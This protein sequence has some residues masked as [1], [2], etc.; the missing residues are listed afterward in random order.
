[1]MMMMIKKMRKVIV[2]MMMKKKAILTIS[3]TRIQNLKMKRMEKQTTLLH[4]SIRSK[5]ISNKIW[6]RL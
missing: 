6:K 2:M 5:L 3:V 4:L 1:M